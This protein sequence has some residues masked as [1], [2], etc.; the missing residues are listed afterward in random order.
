MP[1]H[2]NGM[3]SPPATPKTPERRFPQRVV[4]GTFTRPNR[5]GVTTR[6]KK[7]ET[8]KRM[9]AVLP[10]SQSL[11][12]RLSQNDSRGIADSFKKM[13]LEYGIRDS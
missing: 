10:T 3:L 8:A 11:L 9:Q 5:I 2:R 12:Y 13:G 4:F 6:M 1:T 7:H